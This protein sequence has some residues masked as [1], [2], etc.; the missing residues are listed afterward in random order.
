MPGSLITLENDH[1]RLGL[2]PSLGGSAAFWDVR[3]DERDSPWCPIWRPYA[4]SGSRRI[5]AN[6]PLVPWSNRLPGGGFELNGRF[7]PVHNPLPENPMP[8]HGTGWRQRWLVTRISASEIEMSME[9]RQ[10]E[11][12]PF[13]YQARQR[14][15]IDGTQMHMHLEVTHLGKEPLPYGLGFHPYILRAPG[16]RLRFGAA[17]YWPASEGL[18]HE[19]AEALPAEWNFNQLREIGSGL[20]DHN[21]HGCDGRMTMERPDIDLRLDWQ[22]TQP[23]GL[24]TAILYRP[25][26]DEWFCY[27]PVT[28]ITAAHSR[29]GMPGL[30]LLGQGESMALEVVQTLSRIQP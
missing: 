8:S 17:G 2:L 1:Q 30:R 20:I 7:Y 22:T 25:A 13:H 4:P 27:E 21:F 3:R 23:A 29:A 26:H 12:A 6:F 24:D 19:H 9:T 28:H 16:L 15:Q 10:A 14:Y 11:D 18:P 5:I